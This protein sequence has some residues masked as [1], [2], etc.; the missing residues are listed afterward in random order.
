MSKKISVL[1][2][3]YFIKFLFLSNGI[4]LFFEI[5]L[6]TFLGVFGSSLEANF[7]VLSK[8]LNLPLQSF[9]LAAGII[10]FPSALFF[11]KAKNKLTQL[12]LGNIYIMVY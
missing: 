5:F 8:T 1:V 7:W 4:K 12:S 9:C 3:E 11:S 2:H 6:T 10:K